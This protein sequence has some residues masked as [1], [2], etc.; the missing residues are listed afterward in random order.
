MLIFFWW[1]I[2][3]SWKGFFDH[4][5]IP[6]LT[7]TKVHSGQAFYTTSNSPTS[8]ESKFAWTIQTSNILANSLWVLVCCQP[9]MPQSKKDEC[10]SHTA[11][12]Q[13][14]HDSTTLIKFWTCLKLIRTYV[15]WRPNE[16]DSICALSRAIMVWSDRFPSLFW[17]ALNWWPD[18]E[19]DRVEI[20]SCRVLG[21]S[22]H[23][24]PW[25]E[26]S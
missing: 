18:N 6:L 21:Q 11:C 5:L 15:S 23:D 9:L 20:S 10:W 7:W 25:K 24:Q 22:R 8:L 1:G 4:K 12:D 3:S 26:I 19:P 13:M 17:G 16:N 2:I 14:K